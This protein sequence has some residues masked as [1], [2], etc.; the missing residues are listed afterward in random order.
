MVLCGAACGGSNKC[1]P[2]N[3]LLSGGGHVNGYIGTGTNGAGYNICPD[4]AQALAI[5]C[6]T[7]SPVQ[8]RYG[9]LGQYCNTV[10]S[11]GGLTCNLNALATHSRTLECTTALTRRWPPTWASHAAMGELIA[12]QGNLLTRGQ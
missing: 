7:P 6:G 12:G 2:F 8:W 1:E 9:A 4:P 5:K 11:T 10:C 3:Y